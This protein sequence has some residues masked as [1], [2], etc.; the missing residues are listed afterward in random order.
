MWYNQPPYLY[1]ASGSSQERL[2][3][4]WQ[5][6]LQPGELLHLPAAH[7]GE[8][9]PGGG[10]LSVQP[11]HQALSLQTEIFPQYLPQPTYLEGLGSPE[12]NILPALISF[13]AQSIKKRLKERDDVLVNNKLISVEEPAVGRNNPCQSVR[14]DSMIQEVKDSINASLAST[15]D[16]VA[17]IAVSHGAQT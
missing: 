7:R 15:N 9:V 17:I 10:D 11:H 8:P 2:S 16:H 1:S 3:N 4:W 13:L 5:D 12:V 6:I 14:V